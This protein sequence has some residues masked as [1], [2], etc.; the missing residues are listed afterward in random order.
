MSYKYE[1]IDKILEFKTWSEKRKIDELLRIDCTMYTNMGLDSS[2]KERTE[3]KKRSK[4]IYRT[5]QKL[6]PKV[7]KSFLY[8]MDS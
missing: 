6:N 7:G 5:I 8:Y 4:S 2:I 1:D 3:T